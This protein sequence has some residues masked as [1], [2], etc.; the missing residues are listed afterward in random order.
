MEID[1]YNAG[2]NAY[3][4]KRFEEAYEWFNKNP[5]DPRCAYAL[6]TLYYNAQGVERNF[7]HSTA[8][9]AKAAEAG[10]LPAQVS[11]GFA[12]AN[13]MGVPEDFD[14]AAYYLKMAVAQGEPAAKITLAEIYAKGFAG[15]SRKEAAE[16]IR[17]VL[18][19]TG[20]EEA[21][22][23]YSRYDLGNVK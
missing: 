11:A 20:G 9:Y 18:S 2:M 15:G 19:T 22:D 4:G 17:E 1:V 16:L 7:T 21:Y 12:Y 23:V 3:S 6:G 8:Y 5:E 14:K 10:I 13:A